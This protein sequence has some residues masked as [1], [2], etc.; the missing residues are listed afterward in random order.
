MKKALFI[1]ILFL[2]P[3]LLFAQSEHIIYGLPST[4]H[5]VIKHIG[6]VAGYDS[7]R[8]I[9]AWVF[10]RLI[11]KYCNGS[12]LLKRR[13]RFYPDPQVLKAGL[14]TAQNRCY[15]R[16]GYDRG[17]CFPAA[18]SKG[19]GIECEYQSYS[20][21]NVIPQKP[22]LN[23]KIWL[24]LEEQVR[25]WANEYGEIWIITGGIDTDPSNEIGNGVS[26]PESCYK[27]IVRTNSALSIIAFSMPQ[28]AKGKPEQ[29]LVSIDDIE[30]LTGLDFLNELPDDIENRIEAVTN[31]MW[32][33]R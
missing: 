1:L 14:S 19:R 3:F 5:Y 13:P 30:A 22:N 24:R 2:L 16:S 6:Y 33:T 10:Y 32:Q 23:R 8:K 7:A 9:P 20:L 31:R 17:H 18:D 27:I 15:V 4:N 11:P 28:N 25:K 12:K 26:V 29:Y 21:A